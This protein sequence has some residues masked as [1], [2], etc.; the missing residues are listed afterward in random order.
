VSRVPP[1]LARR[2]DRAARRAHAF[3]RWAHH[4]LCSAYAAEMLRVG[5]A[6]VCKGCALA[7]AGGLAGAALALAT[8]PPPDALTLIAAVAFAVAVGV[9]LRPPRSEAR[10][11][12]LATRAFPMLLGA[13]SAIAGLRSGGAGPAAA[14][15]AGAALAVGIGAYRRRGPARVACE[16]CAE[17]ATSTVCAGFR[18]IA[19]REAALGRLATRW[20]REGGIVPR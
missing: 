10:P 1:A 11:P 14:L 12:K 15:L 13:W 6:R 5:R 20:L 2:I 19:R 4:P 17:R 16:A 8:P 9:A 3:H 18:P 7:W